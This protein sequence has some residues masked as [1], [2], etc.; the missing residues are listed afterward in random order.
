MLSD[1]F[2]R[3]RSSRRSLKERASRMQSESSLSGFAEAQP[4]FEAKPQ[5]PRKAFLEAKP[6]RTFQRNVVVQSD[7]QNIK[8]S[9]RLHPQLCR[10]TTDKTFIGIN[11]FHLLFNYCD[12][13]FLICGDKDMK[14]SRYLPNKYREIFHLNII[15][16]TSSRAKK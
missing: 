5:R 2:E 8:H 3:Q 16:N 9:P 15:F 10:S 1:S 6:Q 13:G 4:F 7:L 12:S 14:I 11:S